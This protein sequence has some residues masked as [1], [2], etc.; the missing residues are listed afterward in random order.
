[1]HEGHEKTHSGP[2]PRLV[3]GYMLEHN[4][5]HAAELGPLADRL[6]EAGGKDAAALVREAIAAYGLG[7]GKLDEALKRI[8]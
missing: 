2:E 1:M 6:E 7:N 8:R 3:L 5:Q 4:R